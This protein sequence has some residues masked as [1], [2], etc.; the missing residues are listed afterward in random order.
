ASQQAA[1][2]AR[3][4]QQAGQNGSETQQASQTSARLGMSLQVCPLH[5][6]HFESRMAQWQT[7]SFSRA[8]D[9]GFHLKIGWNQERMFQEAMKILDVQDPLNAKEVETSYRHLFAINDK[10][11]GGSLYLQS[12]VYRAKERIDEAFSQRCR[13][14]PDNV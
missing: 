12:K 1:A 10:T 11:K 9:R 3:R 6:E 2:A 5:F 4:G 7:V 8:K 14:R 13:P